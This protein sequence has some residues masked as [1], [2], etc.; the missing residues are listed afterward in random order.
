MNTFEQSTG[1]FFDPTS[2]VIAM[3]YAGGDY[4][5]APEGVN[6]PALEA[7]ANVG[8]LP[9]GFY[10]IG[11]P[12]DTVTHGPYALMLTPNPANRMYGRGGFLIH[13]DSVISP[14]KRSASEG[15]IILPRTIRQQIWDSGDHDLH[16]VASFSPFGSKDSGTGDFPIDHL[17]AGSH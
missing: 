9:A 15:C 8:P 16:V 2:D 12:R 7:K 3:G 4:G 5:N 6:N 11:A 1:R 14:G 13:G 10:V 17:P